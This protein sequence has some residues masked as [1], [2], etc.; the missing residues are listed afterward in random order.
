MDE[1]KHC[2][3][4]I[5]RNAK[6]LIIDQKIFSFCSKTCKRKYRSVCVLNDLKQ[7]ICEYMQQCIGN[8]IFE[9]LSDHEEPV[10]DNTCRCCSNNVKLNKYDGLPLYK[11]CKVCCPN[12]K[13]N[14][15]CNQTYYP[16]YEEI[17][18]SSVSPLV[19]TSF[20]KNNLDLL[21]SNLD[22]INW[23]LLSKN[24]FGTYLLENNL[25]K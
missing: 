5:P 25:N 20:N 22:K 3:R 7:L 15:H 9:Y 24:H 10:L 2:K 21:S 1:C 19:D 6:E 4:I 11:L 16:P 13:N 8:L 14:T 12:W 18:N 23:T 17:N